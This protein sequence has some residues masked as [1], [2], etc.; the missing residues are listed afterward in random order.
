MGEQA[1]EAESEPLGLTE[2]ERPNKRR[3][4][5]PANPASNLKDKNIVQKLGSL[6]D[7]HTHNDFEKS[8]VSGCRAGVTLIRAFSLSEEAMQC[9]RHL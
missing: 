9:M 4:I 2:L 3:K 6:R 5:D 7:Y 8:V 1:G